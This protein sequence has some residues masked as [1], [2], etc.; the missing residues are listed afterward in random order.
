[1]DTYC[2]LRC[3][4]FHVALSTDEDIGSFSRKLL[5][6]DIIADR[7]NS[8]YFFDA[9]VRAVFLREQGRMPCV[10]WFFQYV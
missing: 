10:P 9:K 8:E 4:L 5:F 6:T 7:I 3:V 1:M 2:C